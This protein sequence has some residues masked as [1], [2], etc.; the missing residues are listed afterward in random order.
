MSHSNS[1]TNN[2]LS[3]SSSSSV[4]LCTENPEQLILRLRMKEEE[5]ELEKENQ[6]TKKPSIRWEE[7]TIDNEHLCRKSS[8]SKFETNI[9]L[10]IFFYFLL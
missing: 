5:E 3:N 10:K 4:I 1:F 9:F 6:N 2:N 8:K 7:G